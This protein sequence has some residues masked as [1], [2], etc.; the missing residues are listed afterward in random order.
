MTH[1]LIE[2]RD[3]LIKK[4]HNTPGFQSV[5]L[6]KRSGNIVLLVAVD[7]NFRRNIPQSFEGVKVV[8]EDLGQ[9]HGQP[10]RRVMI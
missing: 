9:A 2:K 6:A 1:S 3:E 8:V 5:G 10:M 7:D 4:L